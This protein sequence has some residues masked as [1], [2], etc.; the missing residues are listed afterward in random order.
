M[1]APGQGGPDKP[2]YALVNLCDQGAVN[3]IEALGF[4]LATDATPN[5]VL[6]DS[7]T[8]YGVFSQGYEQ[9]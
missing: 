4:R 1:S 8:I 6:V 7:G 9:Y 2:G 3:A 5:V